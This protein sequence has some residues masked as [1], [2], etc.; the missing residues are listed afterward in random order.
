MGNDVV[1]KLWFNRVTIKA[2]KGLDE[3][4]DMFKS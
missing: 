3:F 2:K 4:R 1:L